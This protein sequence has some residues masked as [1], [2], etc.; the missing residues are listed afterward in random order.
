MRKIICLL[1]IVMALIVSLPFVAFSQAKSEEVLLLIHGTGD[2]VIQ[3]SE[4]SGALVAR[5]HGNPAGRHFAVQT[6]DKSGNLASLLVNTTEP[7]MGMVPFNFDTYD[8]Q[9]ISGGLLEVKAYGD[10]SIE[11]MSLDSLQPAQN[12]QVVGGY[13]DYIGLV[14]GSTLTASV[15]G[16]EELRHFAVSAIGL[17]GNKTDRDL[18]INTT[19]FY[20]GNVRLPN[21]KDGLVLIVKAVGAWVIGFDTSDPDNVFNASTATLKSNPYSP[22]KNVLEKPTATPVVTQAATTIPTTTSVAV[23]G[24]VVTVNKS[25][26]LRG[27][28]GTNY[29]IVGSAK[30]GD[31]IKII[32][33]N[34]DGSWLQ[35]DGNKWI[36]AFLVNQAQAGTQTV[37][38]ATSVSPQATPVPTTTPAGPT[39]TPTT[40]P[41]VAPA[42]KVTYW[43]NAGVQTCTGFEWRVS[44]VRRAKDTWYY[45]RKQA[46]QGEYLIVYVE[47]KNISSGTASFW[48]AKP[49][50]P[51]K[52]IAERSSQYAAWMMT[53]G[54]NTLW[55]DDV[56]PGEF[57]TLVGAFDVAP[58]T[59]TYLFGA[60]SCEQ[61][62]AIG[63]WFELERGPIKASN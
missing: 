19:S 47:V 36:A 24:T 45:D 38:T 9:D 3:M 37:E 21:N 33:K 55:K 10:W 30:A 7:Y 50:M 12:S 63:S 44:N 54:F 13:G 22:F 52:D 29:A 6:Y 16:N 2:D 8:M 1:L 27:G 17:N 11:I 60:L 31:K 41:T 23:S 46:A 40:V 26:N 32:G 57:L 34:A 14:K 56:A 58:D 62:V 5:I 28:P 25:A 42:P 49:T 43:G 35:L 15:Y 59:H 39:A 53:G 4:L 18:L 51:G 61:I 48:E 20:E